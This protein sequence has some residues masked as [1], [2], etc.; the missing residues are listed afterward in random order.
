MSQII[1]ANLPDNCLFELLEK[2]CNKEEAY[3]IFNNESYKKGQLYNVYEEFLDEI[4][5][6]YYKSKQF[7]VERNLSFKM[8]ATIFRQICNVKNIKYTNHIKYNKSNHEVYYHI[9]F[10][11]DMGI[12]SP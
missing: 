11:P 3:Y 6:H 10:H 8:I 5:P 2:I 7:Y 1:K 4:K 9:Y 12:E